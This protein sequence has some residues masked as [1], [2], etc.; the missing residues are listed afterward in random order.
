MRPVLVGDDDGIPPQRRTSQRP[1]LA[2][3]LIALFILLIGARSIANF[4]IELEW[5][6]EIGQVETW[7]S[8]LSYG[9]VPT[10]IATILI[11]VILWT[12]HAR[13]V[14]RGG[15]RLRDHGGY[16]QLAT[17]VLGIASFMLALVLVDSWTIIRYIGA[18]STKSASTWSD[19]VFNHS[20]PFYF[21]ELPLYRMLLGALIGIVIATMLAYWFSARGWALRE[22]FRNLRT[23]GGDI[24]F[25]DL[26]LSE[27]LE[28]KMI[29]VAAAIG[30]LALAARTYLDRYNFLTQD[31]GFMTGI[32]YVAEKISLPLIWLAIAACIAGAGLILIR[33][34]KW[35]VLLLAASI[36]LPSVIAKIVNWLYVRPNEISIQRP[37]I[38]RHIASTRAA[39]ALDKRTREVEFAAKIGGGFNP[40]R[41]RALLDN[42]RLW[43][44]RAFHDTVTQIQALRPYYAFA[45]ADVDRYQLPDS[46]GTTRLRQVLLTPRELSVRQLPDA[47]SWINQH[48]IYTHGYGAV[49]AEANRITSD[50]LPYLLVQNAPPE[51]NTSQLKLTRPEIYY[52]EV[53]H[54]PVFVRTHQLEF[55]YPKGADN[56][57][58]HYDGKGGFPI[59]SIWIRLAAALRESDWNILLTKNFSDESRMMIRR[60]INDRLETIAPFLQ[61]DS[62]PYLVV[63]KEGRLVW[64]ADGYTY[65]DNHPYSRMLRTEQFGTINYIRNSIKATVDA[66]DGSIN[67]YIFDSDDPVIGAYQSLFPRLF[68]PAEE[69]PADLR[70]HARY[71]ETIFR[72]QAE[73]YRIFHMRDPESFYNKEDLWDIGKNSGSADGAIAEPTYLVASLPDS[74]KPEFL[75]M[76]PFT[77][78]NKDN[79]IGLMLARCDGEHLGEIVFLQLSKQ[80]LVFG[81]MQIKARIN[82]DQN[83]AK[84]LSLWNQQGSKVIRG[85]MQVL[86]VDKT[87]LYVEPIYLQAAQAP[88]PQLR[89]VALATGSQIAYADTYEQA[90]AQLTGGVSP[91]ASAPAQP[92]PPQAANTTQTAADPRADE[93]RNRLRRYRELMSQGKF[94][95][96]GRE[97]EAIEALFK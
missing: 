29:R 81:P 8:M 23:E 71:P 27:L 72:V 6:R 37:Y 76:L 77:P 5:W 56:E 80:E 19:P 85:Q 7:L 10:V 39:Y 95:E 14:K 93:A 28:S 92:K 25:R 89:K 24:D 53:V 60:R 36:L 47:R 78:R 74:D 9:I 42:V 62:D 18:S 38:E 79:L 59:G 82:Q 67:L 63:T 3:I 52:G 64:M 43:D 15:G 26:G 22:R 20:L 57:H 49:I 33:R 68:K 69:L 51:T 31:H 2:L 61:W 34:F 90:L 17:V 41:H 35:P 1:G 16:L 88:M 30:F 54:E 58:S 91:Q 46:D 48:F 40:D 12:A 66:Y 32:D 45:G 83:I 50:G 84:D 97:L 11:F 96:A 70:E 73:L 94:A 75:L 13:G 55:N 4:V 65:S 87:F 44:M 86:P 21:F